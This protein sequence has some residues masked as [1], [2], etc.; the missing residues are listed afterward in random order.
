MNSVLV[1][2][3]EDM[4]P[5]SAWTK[6]PGASPVRNAISSTSSTGG[7]THRDQ[8]PPYLPTSLPTLPSRPTRRPLYHASLHFS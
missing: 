6:Q 7:R 5:S 3:A 4:F 8:G 1:L 2:S